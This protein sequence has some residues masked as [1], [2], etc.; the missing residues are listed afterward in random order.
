[1]LVPRPPPYG[2]EHVDSSDDDHPKTTNPYRPRDEHRDDHTDGGSTMTAEPVLAHDPDDP[3]IR[4]G[5]RWCPTHG[6]WECSANKPDHHA[7]AVRGNPHCRF[8]L[9][10]RLDLP[11]ATPTALHGPAADSAATPS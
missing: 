8:H 7:P 5:A 2:D 11:V 3:M 4:S 10:K 9:G 6:W 1:M